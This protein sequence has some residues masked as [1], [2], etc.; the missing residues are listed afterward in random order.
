MSASAE[1][2]LICSSEREGELRLRPPPPRRSCPTL[3]PL[4]PRCGGRRRKVEAPRSE[5]REGGGRGRCRDPPDAVA[6][7][8]TARRPDGAVGDSSTTAEGGGRTGRVRGRAAA[9]SPPAPT[10]RD[11]QVELGAATA[12]PVLG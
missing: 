10:R 2:A 1:D 11:G 5:R 12:P 3:S 7:R 9:S 8:A 6:A 4:R